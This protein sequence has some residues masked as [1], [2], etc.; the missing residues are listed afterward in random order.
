[1]RL[2]ANKAIC[3]YRMGSADLL[4]VRA[5]GWA[6]RR[7]ALFR[8]GSEKLHSRVDIAATAEVWASARAAKVSEL[9][10]KARNE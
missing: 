1:M 3:V 7:L 4:S 9:P 6:S 2:A 8:C 5:Q 10:V